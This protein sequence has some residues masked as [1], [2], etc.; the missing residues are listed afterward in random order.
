MCGVESGKWFR[1]LAECVDGKERTPSV[2]GSIIT[3][4]SVDDST[5]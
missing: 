1:K 3:S 5:Y 2:D 4:G